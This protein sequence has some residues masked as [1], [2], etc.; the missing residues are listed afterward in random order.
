VANW[1]KKP[2]LQ[3]LFITQSVIS[4]GDE[5]SGPIFI[6]RNLTQKMAWKWKWSKWQWVWVAYFK[7]WCK[8]G[9]TGITKRRKPKGGETLEEKEIGTTMEE[10]K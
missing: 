3:D 9:Q 4:I 6:D 2:Q 1:A 7:I 10:E 5:H 8:P